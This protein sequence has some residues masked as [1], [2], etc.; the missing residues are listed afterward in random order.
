M[1]RLHD[2][3]FR[4]KKDRDMYFVDN[5]YDG[6]ETVGVPKAFWLTGYEQK[7]EQDE[8]DEYSQSALDEF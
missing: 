7:A 5:R 3:R 6:L 4:I 1:E 8:L 2:L